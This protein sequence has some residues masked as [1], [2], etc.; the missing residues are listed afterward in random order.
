MPSRISRRE[1]LKLG[2]LALA[3]AAF[4]PGF[5]E[6]QY[7]Y[8]LGVVGRV[9]YESI[10]VFDAPRIDAATVGY[11]FRDELLNIYKTVTPGTGP[12]Y[13]PVWHRVWG[14]WVHSAFVQAVR[15]RY[16]TPLETI[17]A[18]G[19]LC[20]L[21]VPFIQPYE[22]SA[23]G[24]WLPKEDFLL[25]FGS[26]HWV[27]QVLEGPDG[28]AW[29]EITDELSDTFKYYVPA[30]HL[31]PVAD[32]ELTPISPDVP[33]GEKRIEVSLEF[34]RLTAYEGDQIV[35]RTSISSG[36]PNSPQASGLPTETPTGTFNIYSKLPS[37]HMGTS[38]L[39]DTLTD[40][41]LPGVPWTCFFAAGGYALHGAY[42][43]NNFGIP[44][45]RGCINLRNSDAKWLFR[46]ITPAWSAEGVASSADWEARG[47][48]TQVI[49]S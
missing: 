32:E 21:S 18:G 15:P 29:Y 41:A 19:Q 23:G 1:F 9:A 43:H 27:T 28:Y 49:V 34:Q 17:R 44:M 22:F 31:R 6:D 20:E 24:G 42:W 5:P 7:D 26:T 10:S 35:L 40:R 36:I 37:K 11:R 45:S 39:T 14:G 13:N 48:G 38:R 12:A 2:G 8:P 46:W 16:N 25:Y 3:G 33:A 47:F 4:G 30:S